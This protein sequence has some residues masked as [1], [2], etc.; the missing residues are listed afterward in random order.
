MVTF[1][2]KPAV[3]LV[4]LPTHPADLPWPTKGWPRGEPP[5][6]LGTLLDAAFDP[7]SPMRETHAVAL[8]RRG[9]LVGERYGGALPFFDRPPEPVLPGTRLLAWSMAKS[10]LHALVGTLVGD[11]TLRLDEPVNV[12]EW[13]SPGDPRAAIT[14]R[15]LLLMRDGIDF[16]EDYVDERGS[17]VIQMLFGDGA[18][19][20]AAFAARRPAAAEPGERF[21]YSSGTT[22]IIS[23]LVARALGPG[24]GYRHELTERLLRPIGMAEA[25]PGFDDAG[26][27]VASSFLHA[28]AAEFARFGYLYLR[29]GVWEGRRLLPEGWVDFARTPTA[30]DEDG[31]VFGAHWWIADDAYGTFEAHGYAGQFISVVPALDLVVVRLGNT[32]NDDQAGADALVAWRRDVIEAFA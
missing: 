25:L 21:R 24:D 19:D 2:S 10:M 18:A 27:W 30:V 5:A 14:L 28:T 16:R 15:Q 12:P 17:D 11:G 1:T 6:R 20:V 26:T 9:L 22:N 31:A 4:P 3:P 23:G 32:P 8:V 29:D 7:A 13:S